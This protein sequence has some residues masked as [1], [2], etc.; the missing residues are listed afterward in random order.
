[1]YS[2]NQINL[3]ALLSQSRK[4]KRD[5][6]N[7]TIV[8]EAAI[9]YRFLGKEQTLSE[10]I[11]RSAGFLLSFPKIKL[12]VDFVEEEYFVWMTTRKYSLRMRKFVKFEL[13]ILPEDGSSIFLLFF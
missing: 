2:T 3:R 9:N 4:Q 8:G 12:S 13:Y 7:K 10:R 5:R 11:D 6:S 1:M